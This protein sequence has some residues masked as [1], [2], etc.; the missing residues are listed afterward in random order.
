MVYAAEHTATPLVALNCFDAQF[1]QEATKKWAGEL[2]PRPI[3][4]SFGKANYEFIAV[5]TVLNVFDTVEPRLRIAAMAATAISAAMRPY[6]IAVAALL[7][8]TN[9]LMKV[10]A[11]SFYLFARPHGPMDGPRASATVGTEG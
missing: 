4:Y 7:F 5:P 6:S 10:I 9:F 3:G 2:P 8:F 11:L 1:E